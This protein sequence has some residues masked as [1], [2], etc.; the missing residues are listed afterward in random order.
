MKK[1]LQ[2][3]TELIGTHENDLTEDFCKKLNTDYEKGIGIY[4][5]LFGRDCEVNAHAKNNTIVLCGYITAN[6]TKE[7]KALFTSF[8]SEAK[9]IFKNCT[10]TNDL[11]IAT[12]NKLF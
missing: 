6:S 7:C 9:N 5:Y 8:K 1:F 12:G 2:Y 10:K 11:L 4:N 3:Q